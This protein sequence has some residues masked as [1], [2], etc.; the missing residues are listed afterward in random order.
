MAPTAIPTIPEPLLAEIFE[1]AC[2]QA[3]VRERGRLARVCLGA[4]GVVNAGWAE[5]A[6]RE[7]GPLDWTGYFKQSHNQPIAEANPSQWGALLATLK[8]ELRPLLRRSIKQV[9]VPATSSRPI[10]HC[11]T[12]PPPCVVVRR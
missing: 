10:H 12:C 2:A 8:A 6:E 5:Y 3:S 9:R 7:W 11:L 4:R 1:R